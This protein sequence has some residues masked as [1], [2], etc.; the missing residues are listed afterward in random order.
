MNRRRSILSCVFL[1]AV[2][3][4][5]L[6]DAAS[7]Q[8]GFMTNAHP[9]EEYGKAIPFRKIPG[10]AG[11]LALEIS[12]GRLYALES[13]GLSIY[14]I[15]D[16]THPRKL[17]HVGGMGNVRQL[18]V[19]GKTAFVTSRQFGLWAVDV[20]NETK[21]VILS[22][23]DAVEMATGLDVAGDV[24][25]IG[26]RVYGIQCVDVSD[27]SRMK[28]LSS[29][30]TDESQS[31]LYRDNLLFSGDWAGGEVTVI[32]VSDLS[33]PKTLSGIK[34]DGYGDGMAVRGN[35][36]F[37]ST[38]QHRKSGPE[39]GRHGAGHGLDIFDITDPRKPVKLSRVKFPTYY[40]GPC[41]Y[42]TPRISGNLCFASDTINGLFLVDIADLKRPEIIGNL[43]LPKVDPEN[44]EIVV[45]FKQIAD[46]AI[47]QGDPISSIA[48][49]DGVLYMS[50]NF[51]G[52]Y[53][54]EFPA[55]AKPEPRDTGRLPQLPAKPY[56]GEGTEHFHTSGPEPSNPTRG[57]AIHGDIAY[58]ANVWDGLGIHR[59]SEGGVE[60][61]GRVDVKY[62]AD[63]KRSGDRLYVAEGRYGIGVYQIRSATEVVE[64]GR[65][66]V[67]EPTLNFVQF[68]WAFEDS[69]IVAATC[70][71]TKVSFVDFTDPENPEIVHGRS[72]GQ[73]LYG[74]Y[75]SQKLAGGRYFSIARHCGGLMIF[76][77]KEGKPK[78][79]WYDTFPL[80]S[81]TGGVAAFGDE[82]LVMRA[83]GYAFLDPAKPVATKELPRHKFPGQDQLP[84][85]VP[86]ES[87]ISRAMFP[88]GE[89]E[90]LPNHDPAS[91]KL[92]VANRIFKSLHIHDFTDK[93][94]PKVLKRIPLNSNPYPPAFWKGRVV[95]P[96]GYSG[97]LV[98]K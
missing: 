47:I 39:E 38:G 56:Q 90:G 40:F 64:I 96:G 74:S 17:G 97:L 73:L 77:L 18:R 52:I 58:T 69:N 49:G 93:A 61:I 3:S 31:V 43:V 65:L 78:D 75:G 55:Q 35:T 7:G 30:T 26:N 94:A 44:P 5:T 23:F 20:S 21:P 68:L 92:A 16:P 59:L 13:G 34:L 87:A 84:D 14:N 91:G 2:I 89:W 9:G 1:P 71:G 15:D 10:T 82:L 8:D 48:V 4:F 54:A 67:L 22:N 24:A 62:A 83:G 66:S 11:T 72:G 37:A 53:L 28:H 41:D 76:D 12:G 51:T 45:P 46:P 63:V 42:W 81:Q 29:Y 32:D 33:A 6:R 88:K 19:R 80:C 50:G 27:P 98:E 79:V 25:F 70:A 36:L 95:V 85:D 86:D 60:R 57:V